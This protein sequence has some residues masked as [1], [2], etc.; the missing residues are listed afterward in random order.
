MVSFRRKDLFCIPCSH[1][2]VT[3]ANYK[4]LF[5]PD[6]EI[7]TTFSP[8]GFRAS[9]VAVDLYTATWKVVYEP[10]DMYGSLEGAI[11]A[12]HESS[13]CQVSER[14]GSSCI[15]Y[16]KPT[17]TPVEVGL[18]PKY[19]GGHRAHLS[20]D[21]NSN[22]RKVPSE[23]TTDQKTDPKNFDDAP[24]MDK[25][26]ELVTAHLSIKENAIEESQYDNE[27][28]VMPQPAVEECPAAEECPA[29]EDY[30]V[31]EECPAAEECPVA[32][33]CVVAVE[34]PAA[35]DCLDM[36][37]SP[38]ASCGEPIQEAVPEEPQSEAPV[39]KAL[40]ATSKKSKKW[41]FKNGKK[42][43]KALSSF[44]SDA[45]DVE[46]PAPVADREDHIPESV[47]EQT[48]PDPAAEE[49]LPTPQTLEQ[50]KEGSIC[51]ASC[52]WEEPI[53]GPAAEETSSTASTVDSLV[54]LG[55]AAAEFTGSDSAKSSQEQEQKLYDVYLTVKCE[56]DT[57]RILTTLSE[58]TKAGILN[59]AECYYRARMTRYGRHSMP[60]FYIESAASEDG[61][62]DVSL[63]G[64]GDWTERLNF[65]AAH[66]KS[67]IPELTVGFY[68]DD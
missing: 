40:P 67:G 42:K 29:V 53:A 41:K 19:F 15:H 1:A 2:C 66:T 31:A 54:D 34:Y 5:G 62:I 48:P 37:A 26:F 61:P 63:L 13:A 28:F 39:E 68:T 46:D 56:H 25:S 16:V 21:F 36:P 10:S 9:V 57:Y 43:G 33:D 22:D 44:S 45:P 17:W 32:E 60:E 23:T 14:L 51:S 20:G 64:S 24:S 50:A 27:V 30:V 3:L 47:P 12:I 6:T 52:C 65:F 8:D 4:F 49:V 55:S 38:Q 18:N 35:E 11:T 7:L 59:K 58:N